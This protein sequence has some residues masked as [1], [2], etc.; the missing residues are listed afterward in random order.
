MQA[1]G[2]EAPAA[3]RYAGRMQAASL[4]SVGAG[5]FLGACARYV[6]SAWVVARLGGG[7]PFGTMAVNV[8]GSFLLALFLAWSTRQSGLTPQARLLVTVGFFGAFTTFSTY[9]LES[10]SLAR[11]GQLLAAAGNVLG[12]NLLCL[13]G[14]CLGLALASRL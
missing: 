10:I 12:N 5:G 8:T 14:V 7:S 11:D 3:L 4:I 13:A 9:A 2:I 1:G 6:F